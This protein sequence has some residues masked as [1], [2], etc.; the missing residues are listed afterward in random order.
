MDQMLKQELE[1]FANDIRRE[2][3]VEIGT[4][5]VGHIGGT[6]SVAEVIAV[7]YGYAMRYD[8]QNPQ[9][10][11]RDHFVLSKGHAGPALYAALALKGFFSMDWL[12]TL[13]QPGTN[14]P[15]HADRLKTPGVD[16]TTGS[17]GQGLAVACGIAIGKKMDNNSTHVYSLVGDGECNEGQIWEAA[18]LA[19]HRKLDN[20]IVFLDYNHQMLDGRTKDVCDLGDMRQKFEDFGWHAQDINGHDIEAICKAIDL[21]KATPGKPHMIVLQTVKGQGLSR[22]AG[23]LNNHNGNMSLEEMEFCLNE[24][25]EQRKQIGKETRT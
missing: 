19:G 10:E 23:L 13:N 15:S 21:A 20:L 24:I 22:Y 12:K 1:L 3:I 4:L 25:A 17:L 11:G 2:T 16:A 5:G 18:L 8:P 6:M 14:L 7:L 9:W